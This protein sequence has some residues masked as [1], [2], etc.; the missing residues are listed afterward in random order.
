MN[1]ALKLQVKSNLGKYLNTIIE[2][3]LAKCVSPLCHFKV[4]GLRN[5]SCTLYPPLLNITIEILQT[6]C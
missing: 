5:K 2:K 1:P 6:S 4:I 3:R